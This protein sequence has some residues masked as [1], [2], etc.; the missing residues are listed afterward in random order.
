MTTNFQIGDR[1]QNF[2]AIVDVLAIDA[3]RGLLVAFADVVENGVRQ[4]GIGQRY[5]AEPAKCSPVSVAE[6]AYQ[7]ISG[8]VVFA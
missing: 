1:V 6:P 5:Y 2:G 4:G 3:E 8:L 7:H